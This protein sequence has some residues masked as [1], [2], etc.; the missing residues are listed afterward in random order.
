MIIK[1]ALDSFFS[2][3]MGSGIS[4]ALRTKD[5]RLETP[6]FQGQMEE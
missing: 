3:G 2:K 6:D 1:S 5:L 4:N